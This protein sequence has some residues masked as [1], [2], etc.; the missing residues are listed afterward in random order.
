MSQANLSKWLKLII[1][2]VAVCGAVVYGFILPELGKE[3]VDGAPEFSGFFWPWLIFFWVTGIPCYIAL[4]LCWRIAGHIG[5]NRSFCAENAK[6]LQRIAVLAA[7]D[8]GLVFAGNVGFFLASMNHPGTALGLLFVVFA[9]VAVS[10][11]AAGLSH[12][13]QKAADLQEQSDLTI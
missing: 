6:L 4:A 8:S 7:A 12:L 9:G 2:G 5:A 11:T 10:I 1:I 3:L 13:T